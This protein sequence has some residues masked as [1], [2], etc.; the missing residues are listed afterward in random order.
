MSDALPKRLWVWNNLLSRSGVNSQFDV[1]CPEDLRDSAPLSSL[2]QVHARANTTAS[3]VAVVMYTG[4]QLASL[5]LGFRGIKLIS[6]VEIW[7]AS[8]ITR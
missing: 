4:F 1:E 7:A 5:L 2:S 3:A 8:I 6:V